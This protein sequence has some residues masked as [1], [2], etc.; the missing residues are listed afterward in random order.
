MEKRK[1][2]SIVIILL[3]L[4]NIGLVTFILKHKKP[5]HE[6]PQHHIEEVL[7]FSDSQKKEFGIIIK[8]HQKNI[9][10]M[11]KERLN[12]KKKLYNLLKVKSIDLVK[13]DSLIHL[14][15]L[16]NEKVEQIHFNHFTEMK[17]ICEGN[18]VNKFIQLTNEFPQYFASPMKK[19]IARI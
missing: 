1:F 12:L 8:K 18:Q 6:G 11:E 17:S 3:I 15:S 2:S 5:H 16:T 10:S 19:R 9:R 13:K 14:L 4:I 7:G